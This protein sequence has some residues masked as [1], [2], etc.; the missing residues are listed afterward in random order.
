LRGAGVEV[1][2]VTAT[3]SLVL[4]EALVV[5]AQRGITA[6]MVEGGAILSAALVRANLVDE[7]VI[8]HGTR[9]IGPDG[10]DALEGLSLAALTQAGML[11]A[12]EVE[13][14]GHDRVE[15]FFRRTP[16]A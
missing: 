14:I 16:S 7:A 8:F 3:N 4:P 15:T 13:M 9:S 10:V 1:V 11:S 6:V 12:R 5:L 2:R